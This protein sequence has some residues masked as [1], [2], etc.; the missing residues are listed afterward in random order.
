MSTRADLDPAPMAPALS[1]PLAALAGAVPPAPEWFTAA[2]ADAPERR[3]VTVHGCPI[4]A[5]VWGDAGQPGVMLLHGNRA[6][7][8]WWAFL[9]PFL[10]HTH[11]VVALSWSGMGGSGWR[12]TY[13]LDT[14]AD[15][16]DGVAE[17]TGLFEGR[18]APVVVA[19]SFG[20]FVALRYAARRGHRLAGTV[21]VDMPMKARDE[22][23]RDGAT[24]LRDN[25][26]YRDEAAALARFRFAP[27]QPCENL[28]IA[29]HLAR[30]AL[31][32]AE[33]GGV[34]WRFDPFFWRTL[35]L[36]QPVQDM[37]AS[38]CPLA[39]MWGGASVLVDRAQVARVRTK[40]PAGMPWVE[41]PA[42]GHHLMVDQPLAFVAALRALLAAWPSAEARAPRHRPA[43]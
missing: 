24:P 4:E 18:E 37:L 32:P 7:A 31:K 14:L 2:L 28:Y 29:D 26:V 33:G 13:T 41:V 42:A 19:H 22:G 35:R 21:L 8:D 30:R 43:G 34:T 1:A 15:E 11:R 40:Y 5:L 12:D 3:T 27:L 20:A 38:Q 6:H 39:V 9:A 36:G 16:I 23:P 10:R 17:A 25:A